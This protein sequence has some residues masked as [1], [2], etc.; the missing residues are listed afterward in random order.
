MAES[1][2]FLL[3]YPEGSDQVNVHG[4]LQSLV[5][6]LETVL[7][8]LGVSQFQIPV[9]NST[10]SEITVGTP[11]YVAGYSTATLIAPSVASDVY[12]ILGLTKETIAAGESGLVV[13]AGVLDGINL[14]SSEFVVGDTVYVGESGGLT[15]NRPASGAAAVGI[16]AR[17][18]T[19]GVIIVEAKGNGTWG[20]LR[21]GLS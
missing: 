17:V 20:A 16:V 18:G 21:D 1:S 19:D 10:T 7:P 9:I 12:P 4:D 6:R 3:P 14:S 8:P 11:V 2:E 15:P 13:V 5:N